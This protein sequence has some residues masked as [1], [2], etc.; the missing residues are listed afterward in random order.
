V[1]DS[2]LTAFDE[3]LL[4]FDFR[5]RIWCIHQYINQLL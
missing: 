4:L 1:T 5:F 3:Q 2:D